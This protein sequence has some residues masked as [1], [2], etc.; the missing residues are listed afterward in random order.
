MR[1]SLGLRAVVLCFCLSISAPGRAEPAE[2][3]ALTDR[4]AY[5][6]LAKVEAMHRLDRPREELAV[7]VFEL[8]GGDPAMNG[9]RLFVRI[10]HKNV[11]RVWSTGLNV[12][13]VRKVAFAQESVLF[14]T[15]DEDSMDERSRI[16]LRSAV[17]SLRFRIKDG[18]LGDGLTVEKRP[19]AAARPE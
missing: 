5:T 4:D 10:D 7:R 17:Y 12:R 11:S 16:V 13:R 18:A 6:L 9:A 1:P 2:K 8:G 14:L 19:P 3:N 15:V